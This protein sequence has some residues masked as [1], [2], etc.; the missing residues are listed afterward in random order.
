MP[1]CPPCEWPRESP[2]WVIHLSRL[3]FHGTQDVG[4]QLAPLPQHLVLSGLRWITLSP[5]LATGSPS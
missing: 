4:R 1:Y 2:V 3:G 5:V